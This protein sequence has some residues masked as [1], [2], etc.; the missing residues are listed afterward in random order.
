MR[1]TVFLG[2]KEVNLRK[3]VLEEMES[4]NRK[5]AEIKTEIWFSPMRSKAL[6]A[7]AVV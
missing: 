1:Q 7:I 2:K 3:V 4:L 5:S 6:T